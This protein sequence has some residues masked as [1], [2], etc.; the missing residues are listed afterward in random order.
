MNPTLA[1]LKSK[2]FAPMFITMFLTAINDNLVKKGLT[3]YM[4][5]Q[6]A[7]HS[8]HSILWTSLISGLFM[9]P[10][11]LFSTLGG[12]WADRYPKAMYMRIVKLS[13]IPIVIFVSTL[14]TNPVV[15]PLY[16]AL[17][18]FLMGCHSAIFSTAKYSYLPE[19][20][21]ENELLAGN[22]LL[23]AFTLMGIIIG[24]TLSYIIQ[25]PTYGTYIVSLFMIA[26]AV[27]GFIT[28]LLIPTKPAADPN[29]KITWNILKGTQSMV[30][31]VHEN[32]HLWASILGISWFWFMGTF[33]LEQ[34]ANYVHYTLKASPEVAVLFNLVSTCGIGIGSL[35]CNSIMRGKIDLR[36]TPITLFIVS[37]FGLHFALGSN[38]FGTTEQPLQLAQF[39]LTLNGWRLLIDLFIFCFA[40]GVYLVPL[41]SQ[42]QNISEP[43]RRSRNIAAFNIVSSL[44]MVSANLVHIIF[45]TWWG[46]TIPKSIA[47]LMLIN[48]MIALYLIQLIPF[49][50]I[51]PLMRSILKFLF[52]VEVKGLEHLD[53]LPK[54]T[55]VICNHASYLD[56][57]LLA[58]F[59]PGKYCFAIDTYVAKRANVRL[60][61]HLASYYEVDPNNPMKM[62][63]LIRAIQNGEHCII[64][65]EGRFTD[66]GHIMKIY[67]GVS[68]L[69]EKTHASI[70]TVYIDG[71]VRA[72][73]SR[74]AGHT[75][76][77]FPKI[78]INILPP[79]TLPEHAD[80]DTRERRSLHKQWFNDCFVEAK[81]FCRPVENLYEML[82][83]S[84]NDFGKK[85]VVLEDIS[86][87]PLTYDDLFLKSEVLSRTLQRAIHTTKP[88]GVLLPN[89][90]GKVLML[91]AMYRLKIIPALLNYSAGSKN[92][93]SACITAECQTVITSKAFIEKANLEDTI[94]ALKD[95]NI[96]IVYT[97]TLK[98]TLTL[99]DKLSGLISHKLNY[100]KQVVCDT[101]ADQTCIILFTSG[102]EGAPKGV[103][104][105]HANIVHNIHQSMAMANLIPS[106]TIFNVLPM[107]HSFGFT[108]GTWA[109]ILTGCKV[110]LY[111]NPKHYHQVVELIYNHQAT[112]MV[113]T[114]T[115]LLSYQKVA[116][117]H[118]FQSLRSV[119]AGGEKLAHETRNIW[120]N[121]F[122]I[123]IHEGYGTTECSP[124][125]SI[126]TAIYNKP[127]SVG[128]LLPGMEYKL[129]SFEGRAEGGVLN[130]R[131][132]NLM[133]GYLLASRPGVL[134]PP[135]EW[136]STGDVVTIDN[137]GYITI[138]DRAKR[139]AKIAGEMIS[140][141]AI[142]HE[143]YSV[144]PEH[145][146]A[147]ISITEEHKGE[148]LILYT[149]NPDA[150]RKLLVEHFTKNGVSNLALPTK[151]KI[152]DTIPLLGTGKVNYQ[153]LIALSQTI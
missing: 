53:N 119:Y 101:P 100:Y 152:I 23:E 5:Y 153:E 127:G 147:I 117:I 28:S 4:A 52:R 123:N 106:D 145:L 49:T 110:F 8:Y 60:I 40:C 22:G 125:V 67:D 57:P 74:A 102:S 83:F 128:R 15:Q 91:L 134:Q 109:P 19:Y 1:L 118:D 54:N 32:P 24:I 130:L 85:R 45:V 66:T 64:F 142:E 137:R 68:L 73:T 138:V 62:K 122:G 56:V 3:L 10:F 87:D 46:L 55:I 148:S 150:E 115:F 2:K 77:L 17:A 41:Y 112:I 126:N 42:L 121:K 107:F 20:L 92:M 140:L 61:K 35:A 89:V 16:Y 139:F 88:I 90:Q 97:E 111:P 93:L 96:T 144:W 69:A 141:T 59:L 7:V 47:I 82:R 133:S 29:I 50:L 25:I 113:G 136:Y 37:V 120:Q 151:I 76:Q 44:W 9:V 105:S 103:V 26:V 104:L 94:E 58:C 65:P 78:R 81:A 99:S 132:P 70:L 12:E 75:K 34:L 33:F 114:N 98:E 31:Y 135:G 95:H 146:H 6:A 48:L 143:I 11:L 86:I 38:A 36:S 63:S 13:E 30:D 72:K 43:S 21:E 71:V 149:S 131:G 79:K 39:I 51:K 27:I 18:V 80:L 129:E 124:V 14:I 108:L 84:M 116:D